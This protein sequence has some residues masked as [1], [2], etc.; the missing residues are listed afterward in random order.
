MSK[1]VIVSKG[2]YVNQPDSDRQRRAEPGEVIDLDP[3]AARPLLG[4]RLVPY[5][6]EVTP[7]AQ[8][9]ADEAGIDLTDVAGTGAGGKVIKADVE[10]L[11]QAEEVPDGDA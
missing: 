6:P 10:V 1:Y 9:L 3:K 4:W 11:R 7:A 8:K 2:H 5:Q